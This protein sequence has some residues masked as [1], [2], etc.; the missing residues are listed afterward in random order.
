[1]RMIGKLFVAFCVATILAQMIILVMAAVSGNLRTETLYKGLALVNG[2]DIGGDELQKMLDD[3]RSTPNPK[4][5]DVEEERARLDKNLLMRER[6]VRLASEE[7]ESLSSELQTREASHD[8][9]VKEFY[10]VLDRQEADLVD[11]SLKTV[12]QTLESL[13]PEQAKVQILMMVENDHLD[14]VVAIFKGMPL[15]VRKKIMG[16]FTEVANNE[17]QVLNDILMRMRAGEPNAG[18]I[19]NARNAAAQ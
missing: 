15:D 8:R 2:I 9:R 5:E 6:A 7:L 12:Q 16:E 18:I 10:E 19:R 13:A 14:D 3:N 11:V 4:Y 1:M 17:D